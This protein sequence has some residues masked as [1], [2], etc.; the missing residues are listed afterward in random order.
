MQ[1]EFKKPIL[2]SIYDAAGG[3]VIGIGLIL[4]VTALFV[5]SRGLGVG[6]TGISGS[7]LILFIALMIA[8]P[9]FGIAQIFKFIGKAA[10]H[11][12]S[13]DEHLRTS[14]FEITQLLKRPERYRTDD[15]SNVAGEKMVNCP[16]CEAQIPLRMVN[17]G[18]NT[19]P[20]CRQNFEAG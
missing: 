2:G 8:L 9:F 1:K 12:E 16:N 11:S 19:C 13:I 15:R 7:L 18:L 20:D 14:L 3:L 17:V 4:A 6:P 10:F 5:D